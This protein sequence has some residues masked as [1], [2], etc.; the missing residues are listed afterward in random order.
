MSFFLLV[1]YFVFYIV[2]N[3]FFFLFLGNL[4]G[5]LV[6]MESKLKWMASFLIPMYMLCFS[7]FFCLPFLFLLYIRYIFVSTTNFIH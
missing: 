1:F 7:Y 4:G 3:P 2:E 6:K 5:A